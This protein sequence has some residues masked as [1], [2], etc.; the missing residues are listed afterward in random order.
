MT[1]GPVV[2]GLLDHMG[3][4]NLGDAAIQDVV[5]ANIRKRIPDAR[6]V[7][8]SFVPDDTA[9]RHG[10]P[11]HP[12]RWWYPR[13]GDGLGSVVTPDPG[14][15]LK[16]ALKRHRRLYAAL[17]SVVDLAREA[18]FLLRSYRAVRGLDV[19]IISGGGQLGDLWRGPWSHPYTIFKFALL[20][21]LAGRK[22]YF[23][24]V[25]AGPLRHPLSR[26][27]TRWALRLADYRSFRDDASRQLVCRLGVNGENDVYPDP[28]YA[29][30]VRQ[31]RA[32]PSSVATRPVVGV[33]PIGF[34][35]PRVWPRQNARAYQQYL[36]TLGQ[37]SRWLLER[38]YGL[39][40]FTNELSVDRYAIADLRTRLAAHVEPEALAQIFRTPSESV[41]DVLG[42]MTELDFVVTSKF[43]GIVFAHL[44][45]KPVIALSYHPKMDS[46]M[47]AFGQQRFCA[48]I[49]Q[50]DLDWLVG[51]FEAL[52]AES[53][54]ITS[55]CGTAVE[56]CAAR[57]SG[58][59]DR[60]FVAATR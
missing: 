13:A 36:D 41:H 16:R 31:H 57:L 19:L 49:E 21:K 25:G 10:I 38:G 51:A 6:L 18:A 35:D 12:I 8:F 59:F 34:G 28:V 42:E 11:C 30:D 58:Q 5:I 3:Y 2:I 24:N 43:H 4:G 48:D 46:A 53:S 40:V 20:A 23:L 37:F 29:L 22:L 14:S 47:T 56:A 44:L 15:R 50:I 26:F 9:P 17:K 7:A 60:L 33:N 55:R 27:F 32:R 52:V 39:R 45:G 1:R 54:S